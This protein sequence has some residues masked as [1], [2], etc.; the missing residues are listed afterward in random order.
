MDKAKFSRMTFDVAFLQ[1]IS[2]DFT[3]VSTERTR[4][5]IIEN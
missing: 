1:K 3:R 4:Y 5:E 2:L